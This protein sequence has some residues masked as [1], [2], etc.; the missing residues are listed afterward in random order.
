MLG[1]DIHYNIKKY[2]IVITT[3]CLSNDFLKLSMWISTCV[4]KL[5]TINMVVLKVLVCKFQSLLSYVISW[6]IANEKFG[7][8]HFFSCTYNVWL[9]CWRIGICKA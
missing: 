5:S 4:C 9:F 2:D 8:D 1:L 6:D 7:G 3:I